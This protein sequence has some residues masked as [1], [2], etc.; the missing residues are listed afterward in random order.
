MKRIIGTVFAFLFCTTLIVSSQDKPR[1][2]DD[3][4]TIKKFDQMYAPPAHPI[5]FIGSSSIRK[6]NNLSEAFCGYTVLNRGIGGAVL[7]DMIYYVGDLVFPYHPKQIVLYVGEN[8]LPDLSSTTDS[9]LNRTKRLVAL[10]RAK[11]PE[12]PIVYLAIKPSPV[13]EQYV[14]K[15][16]EAN[17]LI[18][19]YLGTQKEIVYVDVFSAM[20]TVD[21]KTRPELFGPDRLHLN[22]TGYKLWQEMIIPYLIKN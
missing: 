9:I 10:I 18:K 3:V 21:G 14:Q 15:A 11:S 22:A 12:V 8:D 20:L 7:N 2:W 6:W 19:N 4:Q 16:R 13:R 17:R 1:Y 5:L